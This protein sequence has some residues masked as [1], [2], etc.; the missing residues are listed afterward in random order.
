VRLLGSGIDALDLSILS[1]FEVLDIVEGGTWTLSGSGTFLE[2]ATVTDGTLALDETVNLSGDYVQGASTSLLVRLDPDGSNDRL[3]V[4][5]NATIEEGATL[6]LVATAPL[7]DEVT[8]TFLTT[9]GTLTGVFDEV[10]LLGDSGLMRFF[11]VATTNSLAIELSYPAG[12]AVEIDIR[13]SSDTNPVNPMSKGVIPVAILGSDTFDVANVDVTTLAFGPD[14]AAPAHKKGG[15]P[16]HVNDDGF[17]DLVSHYRTQETGIAVGDTEACVTGATLDGTP[18]E[19]CDFI[20]TQPN[21]GNGFQAA[22]VLAPLV[23]IGGR[24]RRRRR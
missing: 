13:P 10:N 8:Y 19:G 17:T 24:M 18:L 22:L 11:Q 15:H 1:G 21:C 9:T 4:D 6:Q 7:I 23:W 5:G 2:G 14:G 12:I 3:V 16:Q 20:N